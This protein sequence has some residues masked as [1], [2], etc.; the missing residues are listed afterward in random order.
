MHPVLPSPLALAVFSCS[1]FCASLALADAALDAASAPQSSLGKPASEATRQ[2]NQ[3]V[4]KELD[5]AD[6]QDFADAR[7]GFLAPL[8]NQGRIPAQNGGLAWDLAPYAFVTPL[9]SGADS[10]INLQPRPAPATVHPALWRQSQLVM[11]DGLYRVTERLFQ[12]RNADLSNMTIIEG[13][14]GLIVVD[15]LVSAENAAAALEL[16]YAHRPR[17]PVKVVIY[18]HSHVDHYGGVLGVTNAAD[19][20]SGLVRIIAP[21][22][23]LE[24]AVSAL[25]L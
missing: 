18:S 15:P 8:P 2:A 14:T 6:Q 5:F 10:E 13:N 19:V 25:I 23:F 1:L 21:E 4:L 7:R 3:A 20:Q 12:V 9:Q 16:Y 11:A 24:A 17:K 22:G